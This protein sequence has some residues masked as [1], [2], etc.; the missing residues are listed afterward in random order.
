MTNSQHPFH[1]SFTFNGLAYESAEELREFAV[2]L[3]EDGQEYEAH[4]GQFLEAW[5]DDS[6]SISVTTSGSTGKPKKILHSKTAM[7]NSALATASYFKLPEHTSALLCLPAN[8]I[9]GKM[10]LVRA[11]VLG[12]Q[13]H[14][15]APE[16]DALTQYDNDY[17]FVA[18]VPYQVAYSLPD[19]NKVKKLIVG[20]G[21]ISVELEARLQLVNTEVFATYGMTETITHIA[22]RRINGPARS[23]AYHALPDVTFRQDDRDCL[24]IHCPKI[25]DDIVVTNDI[26][27][28]YS[29]SSF[30][31]LG[32][33][34]NVINS[35]GVKL[36]P[37]KIEAVLSESIDTPF[38]IT[39]ETHETLGERVIMVVES[40]AET[41]SDYS[42]AF[43]LLEPYERPKKVV[44]LSRFPY[45]ETGKIKRGAVRDILKRYKK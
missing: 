31:W 4:I 22:A 40:K 14:V 7:T 30:A 27:E 13:L 38:I 34:D 8:Y 33:V 29:Q 18:M 37:E 36:F 3:Q 44:S 9:A 20:G 45:T 19:L 15:V 17:D 21:P 10:M 26:V 25:C 23:E 43:K 5:L 2:K 28:L 12:W 39:S 35:G 16:K 1:P 24:V 32:R 41:I 6:D 11:L 42:E